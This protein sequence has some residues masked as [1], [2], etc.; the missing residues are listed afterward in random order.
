MPFTSITLFPFA[1]RSFLTPDYVYAY[2]NIIYSRITRGKNENLLNLGI[3]Y[4]VSSKHFF[5][6]L[7]FLQY[8]HYFECKLKTSQGKEVYMRDLYRPT[9]HLRQRGSVIGWI[10]A[11]VVLVV[12]ILLLYW[13]LVW[14]SDNNKETIEPPSV[15]PSSTVSIEPTPSV[16]T[17]PT[18]S[19][20]ITTS[21][22]KTSP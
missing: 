16:T 3:Y 6:L 9:K 15:S 14:S 5:R 22:E 13:F 12:I 4:T 10:I 21:P 17:T 8:W 19:P 11:V 2:D 7:G 20:T 1:Q 18:V